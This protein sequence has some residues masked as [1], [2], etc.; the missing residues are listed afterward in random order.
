[1][2]P[3][4]GR[5]DFLVSTKSVAVLGGLQQRLLQLGERVQIEVDSL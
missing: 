1:M 2:G 3:M 5:N 4:P